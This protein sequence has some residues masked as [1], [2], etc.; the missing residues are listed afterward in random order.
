MHI[1][2]TVKEDFETFL[3]LGLAQSRGGVGGFSDGFLL[4]IA[5]FLLIAYN[6]SHITFIT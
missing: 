2:G 3:H 5:G 4:E 6:I 1:N